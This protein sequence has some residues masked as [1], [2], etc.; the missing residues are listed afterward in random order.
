M[1]WRHV[2]WAAAVPLAA[3]WLAA[4]AL[5][6]RYSPWGLALDGLVLL[7]LLVALRLSARGPIALWMTGVL[8][9][10]L[11]VAAPAFKVAQLQQPVLAADATALVALLQVLSGW[12]L[13]LAAALLAGVALL[14]AWAWWPR[15]G[16]WLGLL[17]AAG[18]AAGWLLGAAWLDGQL[19]RAAPLASPD[20]LIERLERRGGGLFLMADFAHYRREKASVPGAAAVARALDGLSRPRM[21]AGPGFRPR[22]VHVVLIET[23]WDPLQLGH[24]RFSRDPFDPR[25]RRAMEQSKDSAVLVPGF[26]GATANAEFEALCGLPATR[27]QVA[28]EHTLAKPMP[29]LPRLLRQAGYLATASHP[30]HAGFWSRDQA[31]PLLGFERYYPVNAFELDD[32]DGMFLADA[33]TYRQVLARLEQESDPR[34]QFNYVVSL[35]SH[36]P[37]ERAAHRPDRIAVT[38]QAPLLEAYAN[39]I[40]YSTQAFMD[41]VQEVQ[42]RDPDA[43]VVGFGDHAPVLGQ[44]P[45]PY[46]LSGIVL[47]TR[48]DSV[49]EP[50]LMA[51]PALARVPLLVFDGRKGVVPVGEIPMFAISD[52]VLSRLGEDAPRTWLSAFREAGLHADRTRLFLGHTTVRRG[53]HWQLCRGPHPDCEAARSLRERL[54]TLRQDLARGDQHALSWLQI[55]GLSAPTGMQVEKRFADCD[56]QVDAWGPDSLVQGQDFNPQ[57]DGSNTFWFRLASARGQPRLRIGQDLD[58]PL[59][60]AGLNG[61]ASLDPGQR[62]RLRDGDALAWVCP[63]GRQGQIGR[64]SMQPANVTASAQAGCAAGIKDFGPREL[65]AGEPFN[66]QPDGRPAGWLALSPGSQG[67]ELTVAGQ[68]VDYSISDQVASFT[69]D[70]ALAP[71]FAQPGHIPVALACAG[72]V[73]AR[74]RITVLDPAPR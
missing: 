31:Y 57:A 43:L 22:N 7:T 2:A 29:C 69:V 17:L 32:L 18:V 3:A 35:S 36:Y 58:V 1:G 9:A 60:I 68:V 65:R 11:L 50:P 38:P 8:Y 49:A 51:L 63:D 27:D 30:Y 61:S 74:A 16:G 56:L 21:L 62:D 55:A 33:S 24:F 47:P 39:A 44:A 10:L 48:R 19:D 4:A 52:L 46:E 41:Y 13:W 72:K 25:F 66:V 23:A 15:R 37:Y 71:A 34:P 67:F 26:G 14:A 28:F 64:L 40:A 53:G 6:T 20:N 5:G 59:T 73:V 12:R 45:D 54:V 70:E 42:A